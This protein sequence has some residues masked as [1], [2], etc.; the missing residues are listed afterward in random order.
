M[1]ANSERGE[2]SITLE[3]VEYVLRPAYEA[4][5]A[6]EEQTGQPLLNLAAAAD[7]NE[8]SINHTAIVVTECIKAWGRENGKPQYEQFNAKRIGKL[9]YDEG[10]LKAQPR[11]ALVLWAA[12]TGGHKPGEAKATGM[13][14]ETTIDLPVA[15]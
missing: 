2:V 10:L 14:T 7:G 15:S 9:L 5:T 6:I 1:T 8:L 13:T 12:L 4:L 3:G 11:V